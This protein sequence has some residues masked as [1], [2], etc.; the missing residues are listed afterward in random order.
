MFPIV[1]LNGKL[2]EG[3]QEIWG[4][5]VMVKLLRACSS[6]WYCNIHN[7]WPSG[8]IYYTELPFLQCFEV[9]AYF[10]I[11][12]V[13]EQISTW[14]VFSML[15]VGVGIILRTV[16]NIAEVESNPAY[17]FFIP[18]GTR[19]GEV[20]DITVMTIRQNIFFLVIRSVIVVVISSLLFRFIERARELDKYNRKQKCPEDGELVSNHGGMSATKGRR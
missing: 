16:L 6:C 15:I 7:G 8:H 11:I 9:V 13:E 12:R 5:A 2:I 18:S 19:E 3:K 1:D 10:I 17:K 20:T 4:L 14:Y